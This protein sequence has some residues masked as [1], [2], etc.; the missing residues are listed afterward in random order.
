[1]AHTEMASH[2]KMATKDHQAIFA[3]SSRAMG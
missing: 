1:M 3:V 2:T